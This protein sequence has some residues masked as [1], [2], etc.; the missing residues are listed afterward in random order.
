MYTCVKQ[1]LIFQFVPSSRK[2][3]NS[4]SI[5]LSQSCS[6]LVFGIDELCKHKPN[7]NCLGHSSLADFALSMVWPSLPKV[8]HSFKVILPVPGFSWSRLDLLLCPDVCQGLT[9]LALFWF[10]L[11]PLLVI[12]KWEK[13]MLTVWEIFSLKSLNIV[14]E[15]G[16]NYFWLLSINSYFT[17][18]DSLQSTEQCAAKIFRFSFS[19]IQS[20]PL[21]N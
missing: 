16:G 12:W 5:A 10:L 6:G 2:A 19:R 1:K 4:P 9:P 17:R 15:L 20:L 13:F 11:A 21:L 14:F 7:F 18:P 3:K 8:K